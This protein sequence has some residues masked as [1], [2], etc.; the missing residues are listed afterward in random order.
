M[1]WILKGDD[2]HN[3]KFVFEHEGTVQQHEQQ[4]VAAHGIGNWK[5]GRKS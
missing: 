2:I 5:R 1:Q 4:Q 3:I